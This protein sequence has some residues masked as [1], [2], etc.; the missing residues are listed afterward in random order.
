VLEGGNITLTMPGQ[1]T[2]KGATHAFLG[3]GSKAA[4]LQQLPAGVVGAAVFEPPRVSQATSAAAGA[5]PPAKAVA[6]GA[7][8]A[9]A[10]KSPGK[11]SKSNAKPDLTR[12]RY[13]ET[14]KLLDPLSQPMPEIPFR[15]TAVE[16]QKEGQ[17][18][19][20]GGTQRVLT[21][22][23]EDVKF[24]LRWYELDA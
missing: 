10:A 6:P 11:V 17:S 18:D 7:D 16:V 4:R 19:D 1:F 12:P 8:K 9:S 22:A 24:E 21:S 14:F 3:G 2:V 20:E 23:P 15:I 13:N 5:V